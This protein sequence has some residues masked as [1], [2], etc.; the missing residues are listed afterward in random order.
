MVP[1][2][3]PAAS[4]EAGGMNPRQPTLAVCQVPSAAH[5]SV[6]PMRSIS[7]PHRAKCAFLD[8][9]LL[10]AGCTLCTASPGPIDPA[11][12]PSRRNGATE[13]NFPSPWITVSDL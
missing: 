1:I 11:Q 2:P 10:P 4:P 3:Q 13:M 6:R 9:Q 5:R 7:R 8:A 12:I